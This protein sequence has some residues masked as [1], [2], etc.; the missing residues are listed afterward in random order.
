[1]STRDRPNVFISYS[2]K[3][4]DWKDRLVTH[5]GVSQKQRLLYVW[6]DRLIGGG[7]DWYQEI[8]DAMSAARVAILLVSANS[9]TSDFI[10]NEEVER[11]LERRQSEG[12]RIFPIV[13]KPCD[14]EA[15]AW[16]RR[17]NLRPKDG[18]PLS[19]GTEHQIDADLAAIAK[20]VRLRL[21]NVTRV[22]NPPGHAPLDPERIS[23]GRLPATGRDL[24]GREPELD[25]LNAAWADPSTNVVSLIA[26]GG[27]GKSALVN[28]WLRGMAR[29]NYRGAEQVYAWS[30]Y[31]Q[32]T[33]EQGVSAD[34]FIDAALR[35]FGDHD[36]TAGS[37]WD[38]G[39]RLAR[40]VKQQRTLLLLDGLEPLQFPPGRGQQEGAL[41]E[42]SMQALLRELA[43]LNPGLCVISSRLAVTDLQDY[44]GDTARRIDL[45]HLSTQAGA[46]V[47]RAQGVTGEQSELELAS[48]EFGGHALALTLLGSYLKDVHDGDIT[49]RHKVEL[50]KQ[51]EERGG[52]AKRVMASYE[53][54]F[55][56]GPELS[57]LRII[58]LFDR[59]ADGPSIAAL[60][61][62]PAIPGLTDPLQGLSDEDWRRTLNR[63]RG[64]KLIAERDPRQPDTLDA[65]PLVREYF[66]Q[67]LKQQRPDAWREGHHRLYEHL[68]HTT[69]EFPD[70]IKDMNP[71]YAAVAHG[72]AAG[73]YQEALD[74][75][76]WRRIRRGAEAFSIHKLGVFGIELATLTGFFDPPWQQPVP[77]ISEG[78]EAFILNEAGF[79]L[80]AL[81]RLAE[82][83]QP[84][85][86]SLEADIQQEK[87]RN[88]SIVASNLSELYLTMGDLPQ[89]LTYAQKSIELADRSSDNL[90]R[91][92][93][94]AAVADVL[95]HAGRLS[96]S[97][98][99]IRKA[100]EIQKEFQPEFPL[101]Y[102]LAGFRFCALL[103]RQ[104]KYQ[105]VQERAVQT[106]EWLKQ[107]GFILA[108]AM[109]YLSLGRA[110]LLQTQHEAT[111]EF[112]Q[113][114]DCLN[115][116]V[117]DLR[118]AGYLDFL[119]KGLLARAEL[120]R[121]KGEFNRA[122]VDLDEA[123]S[124]ATR[125]SM[126]LYQADCYLEYARLHLAQ[127][128][129]GR[130]RKHWLKAK[131]MIELMGYHLRD[132]EVREI[133]GL[134]Q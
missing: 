49:Q 15:V 16:L 69:K 82:A 98:V 31:R 131:E 132:E 70:T 103:L 88:G 107:Y 36:P 79:V 28:Y 52:H 81:G 119:P 108:K 39:E 116:A 58:G 95:Y 8:H 80:R 25:I 3:D 37:P 2:H 71:L 99:A 86:A 123:I 13:I 90:Q 109:D 14:W 73:K 23:I 78:D 9:L 53:K 92:N 41:K 56:D 118:R 19:G 18:R 106:L 33:S 43:A 84:M 40:L 29:D 75:V 104:G 128:E 64:A 38:K 63:L 35:W 134:L 72:C 60:R 112:F 129:K 67:R 10:L 47:L 61:A 115:R 121:V 66:G 127:G 6:E 51:D 68:K 102:S 91:M 122:R 4:E 11:L 5:L 124:I 22:S 17:M 114:T 94:T 100:E 34:Q 62:A 65:H 46:Q 42:H 93:S 26:W 54:W 117:Y 59:P 1:M 83:V 32:G 113:A 57:V 21:G 30:F 125:G 50:L 87:W 77:I 44:E 105:E 85:R 89:A 130:A 133:E 48:S 24:F 110:Y 96:E 7:D 97:E 20:E 101:L 74:E 27:V 45:E 126:G 120:H 12:I 111:G 76:Y 55:G